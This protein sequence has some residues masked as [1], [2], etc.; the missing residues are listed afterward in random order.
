MGREEPGVVDAVGVFIDKNPYLRRPG[1]QKLAELLDVLVNGVGGP[2]FVVTLTHANVP[3]NT[4]APARP[5]IRRLRCRHVIIGG[6]FKDVLAFGDIRA[7]TGVFVR[8]E[9]KNVGIIGAGTPVEP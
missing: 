5:T 9:E 1:K 2:L 3:G 7:E 8:S 4:S 6:T